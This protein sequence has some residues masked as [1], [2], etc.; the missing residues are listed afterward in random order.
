VSELSTVRRSSAALSNEMMNRI[1]REL[2]F[3]ESRLEI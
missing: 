3:E 1:L 2:D